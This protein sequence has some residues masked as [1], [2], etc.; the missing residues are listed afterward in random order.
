MLALAKLCAQ[1]MDRPPK[2]A[3]FT[4]QVRTRVY[5]GWQTSFWES[6]VAALEKLL[7][8]CELCVQTTNIFVNRAAVVVTG[9]GKDEG[10]CKKK[11]RDTG[12]SHPNETARPRC[13]KSRLRTSPKIMRKNQRY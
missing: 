10:K 9:C 12:P 5:N 6:E 1:P 4:V 7:S 3:D 8:I 11:E 13:D 2:P